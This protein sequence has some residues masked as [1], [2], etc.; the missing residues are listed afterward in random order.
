MTK[1]KKNFELYFFT[2]LMIALTCEHL[3][4]FVKSESGCVYVISKGIGSNV[5]G[6]FA[7]GMLVVMSV[8]SLYLGYI[9]LKSFLNDSQPSPD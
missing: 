2:I 7:I 8:V 1:L 9:S 5:C 3:W 6:D 4:Q